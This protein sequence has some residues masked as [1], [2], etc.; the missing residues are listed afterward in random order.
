MIGTA[1]GADKK[2]RVSSKETQEFRY[3]CIH[4]T[5]KSGTRY[6]YSKVNDR[7]HFGIP[8]VIFGDSGINNPVIDMDGSYGMTQHSMG[9]KVDNLKDATTICT[10]IT[11]EKFNAIIQSCLFSSYAIDWNIFKEFK[12]DFWKEFTLDDE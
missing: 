11:S 2:D 4:S 10:V 3:P 9:I 12:Y 8:K 1:Y 6:M 7:G 5:P